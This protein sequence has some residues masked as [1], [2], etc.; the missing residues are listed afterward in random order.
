[1]ANIKTETLEHFAKLLEIEQKI[2]SQR[3]EY[4]RYREA[5]MKK[6][7]NAAA[8]KSEQIEKNNSAKKKDYEA[9]LLEWQQ[10]VN[11]IDYYSNWWL[12][13][14]LCGLDGGKIIGLFSK[15][16]SI[17]KYP[18]G[19]LP[20]KPPP[21]NQPMY[22]NTY[23]E[24]DEPPLFSEPSIA[25]MAA[26]IRPNFGGYEWWKVLDVK[27]GKA[28]LLSDLIL[29]IR[30]YHSN[31][32]PITWEKC[33][34]RR[35]LNNNFFNGFVDYEK[36]LIVETKVQNENNLWDGTPGG[37]DTNDKIFLLSIEEADRYFGNSQDYQ[38]KRSKNFNPSTKTFYN[39]ANG[40]V[41]SNKH[42]HSRRAAR[43]S[44][45]AAGLSW[46]DNAPGHNW[47]LRT[48][49]RAGAACVMTVGVI[50]VEGVSVNNNHNGVSYDCGVRPAM[51]VN[52]QT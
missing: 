1:M 23:V 52:L 41:L 30:A 37:P 50:V 21:P 51:W 19:T 39:D 31:E 40:M 13:Q 45:T 20:S 35:Y 27:D 12:S 34:L 44:A 15:K 9:K 3:D 8:E 6:R 18:A 11:Q 7:R 5:E 10:V 14:G 4:E 24:V 48:P 22:E 29:D 46:F 26:D 2:R 42:D 32:M 36:K 16:C 17:C 47:W 49:G 28:L 38:S 43:D 33:D 25:D